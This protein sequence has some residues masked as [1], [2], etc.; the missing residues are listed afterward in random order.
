MYRSLTE[1]RG[2]MTGHDSTSD[3]SRRTIL[4]TSGAAGVAGLTGLSGCLSSLTGGTST[5]E[6]LHPWSGGDGKAAFQSMQKG[7]EGEHDTELDIK[8]IGGSAT[9]S[10]KTRI[11]QRV[12]NDNPP[13]SWAD[14]PGANL[15]QYSSVDAL[16]D[17][18]GDVWDEDV[19]NAYLQGPKDAAKI[20]G[21]FVAVPT[22]IHRINNL[23]YSKEVVEAAGV[24][25]SSIDSPM[26][27]VD[28]FEK[29]ESETDAVGFAHSLKGPWTSLQL[30][31][32]VFIGQH[33]SDAYGKFISGNGSKSKVKKSLEALV[34]YESHMPGDASS[35]S[36]QKAGTMIRK[37]NAA[38]MHQGD[39]LAGMFQGEG[40]EFEKGWGH[41]PYPGSDGVYQ[42]NMDSWVFPKNNP[43]PKGTKQWL[44]YCASKDAQKRFNK[45]K[46]SIPPRKDVSMDDFPKFQTKQYGEFT[47]SDSQPPSLAHG[48]AVPKEQLSALKSALSDKFDYSSGSVDATATAFIDAVSS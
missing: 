27:L 18:E 45:K 33:G 7:F 6:L 11:S 23:F 4:K 46:G 38:F 9:T 47:E 5:V 16:G 29:V 26:A 8:A 19:K 15:E 41:V 14:W 43:S 22:N 17:I 28:A 12:K 48:L 32:S 40:F 30:F 13:S 3:V 34:A 36:F 20:D 10:L 39:W 1:T 24:D 31:A 2:G 42:L 44:S 37:G 35:I 25:P 21:T